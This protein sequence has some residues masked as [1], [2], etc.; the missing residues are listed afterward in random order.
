MLVTVQGFFGDGKFILTKPVQKVEF[1]EG[2][3]GIRWQ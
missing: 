3:D 2:M 1:E